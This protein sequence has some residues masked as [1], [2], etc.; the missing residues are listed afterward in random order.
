MKVATRYLKK[1]L[2]FSLTGLTTLFIILLIPTLCTLFFFQFNYSN[3]F[4]YNFFALLILIFSS[5]VI[6]WLFSR[7]NWVV[8]PAISNTLFFS[9]FMVLWLP[10]S[11]YESFGVCAISQGFGKNWYTGFPVNPLLTVSLW[12]IPMPIIY[13]SSK[14][15]VS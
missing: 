1:S 2:L 6:P 8:L 12:L 9:V 10:N 11:N 3:I 15:M 14:L 5:I 4:Y 7:F 13:I